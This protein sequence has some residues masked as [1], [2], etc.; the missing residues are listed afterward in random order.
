MVYGAYIPGE[1]LPAADANKGFVPIGTVLPFAGGSAPS[2]WIFCYGQSLAVGSA[3]KTRQAVATL[4]KSGVVVSHNLD[5][6]ISSPTR[7][8]IRVSI[9]AAT[10]QEEIRRLVLALKRML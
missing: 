1:Q 3:Q 9:G 7:P 5:Y 10:T 4:G 2:N 8:L 6:S